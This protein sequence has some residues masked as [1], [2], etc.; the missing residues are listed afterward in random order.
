MVLIP[1]YTLFLS[2]WLRLNF[3]SVVA[4]EPSML[5]NSLD[6]CL[7]YAVQLRLGEEALYGQGFFPGSRGPTGFVFQRRSPGDTTLSEPRDPSVVSLRLASYHYKLVYKLV[8]GGPARP[9]LC[10]PTRF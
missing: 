3:C 9:I 7:R 10:R 4:L 8:L 2:C 1:E 6:H 5:P